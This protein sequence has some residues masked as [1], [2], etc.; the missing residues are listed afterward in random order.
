[1]LLEHNLTAKS[2]TND[3]TDVYNLNAMTWK[4]EIYNNK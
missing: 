3:S 4:N 2:K 1:M